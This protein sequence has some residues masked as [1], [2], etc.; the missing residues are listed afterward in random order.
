M[1]SLLV[2]ALASAVKNSIDIRVLISMKIVTLVILWQFLKYHK[3]NF[4]YIFSCPYAV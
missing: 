4:Y 3:P 2:W 1:H